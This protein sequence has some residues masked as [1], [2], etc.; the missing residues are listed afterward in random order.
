M[1]ERIRRIQDNEAHKLETITHLPN[2]QFFRASMIKKLQKSSADHSLQIAEFLRT[3]ETLLRT[4]TYIEDVIM[5]KSDEE[6]Y[7]QGETS[8]KLVVYLFIWDRYRMIAK[9]FILQTSALPVTDL[10]LE[11]HERMAR[12]MIF[13]DHHM[14]T[15]GISTKF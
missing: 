1:E 11:C 10:W 3:P 7:A 2:S 9:D 4:V 5:D 13:M 12:W 15:E 8:A 6:S 14:K